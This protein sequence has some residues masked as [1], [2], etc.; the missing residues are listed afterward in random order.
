[1]QVIVL[2]PDAKALEDIQNLL[3]ATGASKLIVEV[4]NIVLPQSMLQVKPFAQSLLPILAYLKGFS[5]TCAGL[6]E[7]EL[8]K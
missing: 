5:K 3:N 4:Q 8:Q 1:M 7:I 6:F 2:A